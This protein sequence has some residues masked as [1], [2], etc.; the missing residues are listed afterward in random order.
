MAR[1]TVA[2][3]TLFALAFIA[4]VQAGQHTLFPS[5]AVC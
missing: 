1:F 3:T 2:F 5:R 4:N